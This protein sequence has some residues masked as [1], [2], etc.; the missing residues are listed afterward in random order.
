MTLALFR[1]V[2]HNNSVFHAIHKIF[3]SP[4][5]RLLSE[6][7][8]LVTCDLVVA[9]AIATDSVTI[10]MF[11]SGNLRVYLLFCYKSHSLIR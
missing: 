7:P 5:T 10:T 3:V 9:L 1:L 8:E 2:T 6:K 4:H 11:L